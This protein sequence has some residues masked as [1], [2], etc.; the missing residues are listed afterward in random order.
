VLDERAIKPGYHRDASRRSPIVV[1]TCAA[2]LGRAET[3]LHQ[4]LSAT[5]SPGMGMAKARVAKSIV[6]SVVMSAAEKPIACHEFDFLQPRLE[7][8]VE[9]RHALLVTLDQRWNLLVVVWT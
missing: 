5:L 2:A 3:S 1:V 7:I 4:R 9:V 6:A 8:A